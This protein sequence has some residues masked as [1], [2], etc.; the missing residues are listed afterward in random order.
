MVLYPPLLGAEDPVHLMLT[1][2]SPD[3]IRLTR[4]HFTSA[5]SVRSSKLH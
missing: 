3:M 5:I 1:V 2:I 4:E